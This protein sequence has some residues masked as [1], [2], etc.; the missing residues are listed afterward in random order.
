MITLSS[1]WN[2]GICIFPAGTVFIPQRTIRN[3]GTIY[4]YGTPGG[5]HGECLIDEGVTPGQS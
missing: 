1:P 3:R 2:S 5:G 4:T